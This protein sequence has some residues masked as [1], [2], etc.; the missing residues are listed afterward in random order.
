MPR[1]R[2]PERVLLF[3]GWARLHFCVLRLRKDTSF[4]FSMLSGIHCLQPENDLLSRDTEAF[5]SV[6]TDAFLG[7]VSVYFD[8]PTPDTPVAC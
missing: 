7:S 2:I 6:L 4:R 1:F 8:T 3:P 5:A